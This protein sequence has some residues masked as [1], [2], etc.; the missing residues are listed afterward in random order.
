M[1]HV[2]REAV[3]T[4]GHVGYGNAAWNSELISHGVFLSK[5]FCQLVLQ[6]TEHHL[7]SPTMLRFFALH[8][9]SLSWI[10]AIAKS[11]FIASSPRE[12]ISYIAIKAILR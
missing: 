7:C 1:G 8:T 4:V 10:S 12:H 9:A 6:G 5:A 11:G 2:A 3:V